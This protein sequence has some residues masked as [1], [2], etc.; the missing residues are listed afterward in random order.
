MYSE[1][2][3]IVQFLKITASENEQQR[4]AGSLEEVS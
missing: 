2:K 1:V 3:F 4:G